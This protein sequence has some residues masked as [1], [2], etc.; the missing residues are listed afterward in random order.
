MG[1]RE[2]QEQQVVE[3]NHLVCIPRFTLLLLLLWGSF[4]SN[5]VEGDE[6]SRE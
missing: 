4:V 2:Y 1:S 5:E 3:S 6:R